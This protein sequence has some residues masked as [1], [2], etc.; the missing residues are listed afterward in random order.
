MNKNDALDFEE[1]K[2]QMLKLEK[3]LIDEEI[4]EL[5]NKFDKNKDGKIVQEEFFNALM[6]H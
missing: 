2:Q 3:S 6:T 5:F 1:F 4:K